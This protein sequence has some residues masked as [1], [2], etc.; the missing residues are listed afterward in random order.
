MGKRL[1]GR[2]V[3]FC[4]KDDAVTSRRITKGD[5]EVSRGQ[6]ENLV[7]LWRLELIAHFGPDVTGWS[8]HDLDCQK[9]DDFRNLRCTGGKRGVFIAQCM[10]EIVRRR[11]VSGSSV[12]PVSVH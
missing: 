1:C 7:E 4:D 8:F 12:S 3:V 11:E 9:C 6:K 10:L 5:L 2:E